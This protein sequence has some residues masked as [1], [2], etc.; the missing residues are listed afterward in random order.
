MQILAYVHASGGIPAL[1]ETYSKKTTYKLVS[2]CNDLTC[3][4]IRQFSDQKYSGFLGGYPMS[5]YQLIIFSGYVLCYCDLWTKSLKSVLWSL[6]HLS[7][8]HCWFSKRMCNI[9]CSYN[10][11]T[12]YV[13]KIHVCLHLEKNE[14][15]G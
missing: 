3:K 2:K 8:Q 12:V 15:N 1:V 14:A 13:Y 4:F 6:A 5:I 11:Y 10:C 7:L 9:V